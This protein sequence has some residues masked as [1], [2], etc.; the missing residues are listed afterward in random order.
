[1]VREKRLACPEHGVIALLENRLPDDLGPGQLIVRNTHG[2]EKHGTMESFVHKHG[3]A[4]GAW[5][6]ERGL[7]TTGAGLAW[8]Y[9]IPLGNMQ[10]GYVERTGLDCGAIKKGDRVLY[11]GGFAA[12][13]VAHTA[14]TWKISEDTCWKAA[15]CLDPATFAFAALRDAGVRIG[16]A[17]AVFGLGAIGLCAVALA[18]LAGCHPVVAI[19][20][21]AKRRR[22]AE[23]LGADVSMD[24]VGRDVGRDLRELSAWR[25]VDVA[26]EYS[27]TVSALNAALRGVA[28]GGTVACGAFPAPYAAGLDFGGEAHMNRPNIIFT[29]A[30]SDPGRDHPRWDK[31][32]VHRAV[33]RLIEEGKID[34]ENIVDPVIGFSDSLVEDYQRIMADRENFVKMG[35]TYP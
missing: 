30:E 19:D 18:K 5:D 27:G 1:M 17:V 35:V 20:P 29:R 31:A 8:K 3:N 23:K 13:G 11:F 24:P 10:V 22:L 2:A 34:G 21:V 14:S 6:A 12:A 33:L 16:D 26:V 7:H 9:P 4:R 15:T 28:F 32:R 25:G